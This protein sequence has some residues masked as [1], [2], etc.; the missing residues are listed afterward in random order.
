MNNSQPTPRN[1]ASVAVLREQAGLT[2][3]ELAAKM[4][5]GQSALSKIEAST[6]APSRLVLERLA[7]VLGVQFTIG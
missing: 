5:I 1:G 7:A 6:R 4:T 3:T 2:Q